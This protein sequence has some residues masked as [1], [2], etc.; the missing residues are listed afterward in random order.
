MTQKT[1]TALTTDITAADLAIIKDIYFTS[2][3]EAER[4]PW[5]QIVKP[6][7]KGEPELY[8]VI[9][10]SS[11]AGMATLWH[12][13]SFVYIEHLAVGGNR[14]NSGLGTS[15]LQNIIELA[16]D[17]PVVIE[18]EPPCSDDPM[19][20]RRIAFYRRNGFEI[21]DRGYIQPPYSAGLPEVNLYLMSTTPFPSLVATQTL[22]SRVY[23]KGI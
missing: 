19:T 4:R 3:P 5:E 17:K 2:F 21:I 23:R 6:S 9:S 1:A 13:D 20:A 22:H 10:G 12:F 8:A 11:L 14:R 7:K 16:G 15:A 18:V